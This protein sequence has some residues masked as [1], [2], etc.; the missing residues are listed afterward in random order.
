MTTMEVKK[1]CKSDWTH[2][3]KQCIS[4]F[5]IIMSKMCECIVGSLQKTP[6][7][8][9]WGFL[10]ALNAE[11]LCVN[12]SRHIV[13][14]AEFSEPV[15][16]VS[17][18]LTLDCVNPSNLLCLEIARVICRLMATTSITTCIVKERTGAALQPHHNKTTITLALMAGVCLNGLSVW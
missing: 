18:F 15:W 3:C 7:M 12:N 1:C 5:T 10:L 17:G 14:T 2:H 13:W 4:N 6:V 16:K 11:R 8:T 9:P